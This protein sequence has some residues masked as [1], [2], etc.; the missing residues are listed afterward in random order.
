MAPAGAR[1]A[2]EKR[3][4]LATCNGLLVRACDQLDSLMGREPVSSLDKA[5]MDELGPVAMRVV[6]L[7]RRRRRLE[8]E[9]QAITSEWATD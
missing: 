3:L 8:A 7:R 1:I 9:L 2:R 4:A 5:S 6:E